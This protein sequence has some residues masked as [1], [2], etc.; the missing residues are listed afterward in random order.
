[1]SGI[2]CAIRGGPTSQPTIE[3]AISLARES[4][5]TL[6]FLYVV[7]LDFLTYSESGRIK[8]ISDELHKMGDFI[9]LAA[10][11]QAE[12]EG[13]V[14]EIVVRQGSVGEEIIQYSNEVAADFV[15][16]GRPQGEKGEEDV[17]TS[18]RLN[19]FRQRIEEE[20]GARVIIAEAG[21]A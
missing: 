17:F 18:E 21:E 11:E 3:T 13:V 9:L 4:D 5:Q 1:M 20:S 14:T 19:T 7:N 8:N 16:L 2:V 10:Q 12:A 15:V 6:H